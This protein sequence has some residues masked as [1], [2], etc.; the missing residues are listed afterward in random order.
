MG[1]VGFVRVGVLG[2]RRKEMKRRVV[3]IKGLKKE[4]SGGK[5]GIKG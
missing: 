4:I 5:I 3:E 1:I 2:F